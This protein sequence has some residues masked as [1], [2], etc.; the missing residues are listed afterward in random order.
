MADFLKATTKIDLPLLGETEINIPVVIGVTALTIGALVFLLPSYTQAVGKD[1]SVKKDDAEKS[2]ADPNLTADERAKLEAELRKINEQLRLEQQKQAS[3]Q[4]KAD[5][6]KNAANN[7]PIPIGSV[8]QRLAATTSPYYHKEADV[9]KWK[10]LLG[11]IE[12]N[13]K[14]NFYR[15][16]GKYV[17]NEAGEIIPARPPIRKL[18]FLIDPYSYINDL[19]SFILNGGVWIDYTDYPMYYAD[20]SYPFMGREEAFAF[21]CK[22]L[23]KLGIPEIDKLGAFSRYD[24]YSDFWVREKFPT[25]AYERSLTTLRSKPSKDVFVTSDMLVDLKATVPFDERG[26][27]SMFAIRYGNGIYFYSNKGNS[28]Y[29]YSVFIKAI[30]GWQI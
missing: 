7:P 4:V 15:G 29:D 25:F 28:A 21:F 17:A 27:Y 30:H 26:A 9:G 6:E 20:G 12:I 14:S 5:A 22:Q 16:E 11:L 2:L 19:A 18:S 3:Q 24:L 10:S 23:G 1:L 13:L 8:C